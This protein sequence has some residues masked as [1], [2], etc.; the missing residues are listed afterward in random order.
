MGTGGRG[1]RE[2]TGEG[3]LRK[4]SLFPVAMGLGIHLG[5]GSLIQLDRE[6]KREVKG[7]GERERER[8]RLRLLLRKAL[9]LRQMAETPS[10]S[11]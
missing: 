2:F 6:R 4:G 10:L 3:R 8:E 1:K 7:E 9:L 5:V 11:K